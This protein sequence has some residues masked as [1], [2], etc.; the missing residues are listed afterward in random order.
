MLSTPQI[1]AN[2]GP[3]GLEEGVYVGGDPGFLLLVYYSPPLGKAP[4]RFPSSQYHRQYEVLIF[5]DFFFTEYLSLWKH[6]DI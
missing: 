2:L 3:G 5:F 4:K 1:I 6:P